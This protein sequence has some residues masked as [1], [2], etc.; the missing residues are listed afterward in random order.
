[1]PININTHLPAAAT[2]AKEGIFVM[3]ADRAAAQDIRPL[4]ILILNIMPT[5]ERTE[6]QLIRLLA[7]S[8]L[9]VEVDLLRTVSYEAR[10]ASALHLATFYK[11]FDE[12]ADDFYDGLIVTGAPVEQMPFRQVAYWPEL[13]D[14]MN[15]AKTNVYSSMFICWGAQAALHHYYGLE[16]H[17]L[18]EKLS[19]VF[20]HRKAPTYQPLLRGFDDYFWAPHSR[21]TE[22]R[23]SDIDACEAVDILCDGSECGVY[24]ASA[25]NGRQIFVMGHPEYTQNTLRAEYMRDLERGLNP[26]IPRNY[27]VH[28][29]PNR[30]VVVNWRGHANMLFSN[31]LNYYVY[32]ETPYDIRSLSVEKTFGAPAERTQVP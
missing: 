16:K 31:W 28:N 6:T 5:K 12:V 32:Q 20:L 17:A 10:H 7:N 24:L 11:T 19:G 4:R 13:Q 2:L 21:N 15:W 14:I 3:P 22:I 1:M 9:Q 30:D 26:N 29:D 23:R 25:S 8:P 18:P 27:F